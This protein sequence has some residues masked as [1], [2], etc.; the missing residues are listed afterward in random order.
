MFYTSC[1]CDFCKRITSYSGICS[2]K[3]MTAL[4]RKEGWTI[5]KYHICG[6]CQ[7]KEHRI[8]DDEEGKEEK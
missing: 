2:K 3:L 1:Q 7:I 4:M 6:I 5:G 8:Q